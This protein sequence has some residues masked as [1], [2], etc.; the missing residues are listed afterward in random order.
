MTILDPNAMWTAAQRLFSLLFSIILLVFIGW[1]TYC[2]M[3]RAP[4]TI[5][6]EM[7]PSSGRV[8]AGETID[9]HFFVS[10]NAISEQKAESYLFDGAE[11]RWPY[12]T[13]PYR[14]IN[15]TIGE[16]HFKVR[17]IIPI[18]ATP[19]RARYRVVMYYARPMNPVH[20][21]WPVVVVPDDVEFDIVP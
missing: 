21:I 10:R 17:R 20:K 16:D 5:V 8:K 9:I 14:V 13:S 18:G 4:P 7:V 12:P 15:D 11:V 2:A 6:T 19:G 3:D 1:I